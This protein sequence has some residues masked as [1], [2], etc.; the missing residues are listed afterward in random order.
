MTDSSPASAHPDAGRP[1][2][3]EPSDRRG[4]PARCSAPPA[5]TAPSS[6]RTRPRSTTTRRLERRRDRRARLRPRRP[7][8]GGRRARHPGR[9]AR[10]ADLRPRRRAAGRARPRHARRLPAIA[11]GH[12]R[13]GARLR[14]P[15]R[16]RLHRRPQHRAAD[17]GGDR[18]RVSRHR[19]HRDRSARRQSVPRR[20]AG[21]LRGDGPRAVARP[22][23][24]DRDRGAV[25]VVGE[26]GG[27]Q[28]AV[29]S[30]RCRSNARCR[31]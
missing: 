5:S 8:L 20:D 14:Y 21:V 4:R 23:A 13:R 3:A 16:G 19:P 29:S 31:A 17:Q 7:G 30:W 24:R 10:V 2:A 27:D 15:G 6:S 22:G 1:D 28:R 12:P 11:L 18:V 26:V 25:R 9:A